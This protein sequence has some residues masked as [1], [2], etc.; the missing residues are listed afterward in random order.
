MTW[1][2]GRPEPPPWLAMRIGCSGGIEKTRWC[3]GRTRSEAPSLE[4]GTRRR[5]TLGRKRPGCQVHVGFFYLRGSESDQA[6]QQEGLPV[7][8]NPDATVCYDPDQNC[9]LVATGRGFPGENPA[10]LLAES[11]RVVLPSLSED[12][13]R[14]RCPDRFGLCCVNFSNRESGYTLDADRPTSLSDRE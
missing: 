10:S 3:D 1:A 8:A 12:F 6:H 4:G 11:S 7:A 9:R 13:A 5:G 2:S 14:W